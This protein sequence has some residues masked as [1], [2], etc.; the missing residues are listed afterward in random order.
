M[1]DRDV[2]DMLDS[3]ESQCQLMRSRIGS[4]GSRVR[5]PKRGKPATLADFDAALKRAYYPDKPTDCGACSDGDA[6]KC[7]AVPIDGDAATEPFSGAPELTPEELEAAKR[8]PYEF[9]YTRDKP[10]TIYA[11]NN[12]TG[13]TKYTV[14]GTQ[15]GD[16]SY[17]ALVEA[18]VRD[19]GGSATMAGITAACRLSLYATREAVRS[20]VSDG[21]L[22]KVG[23]KRGASYRLPDGA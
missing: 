19:L 5:K 22:I 20:L 6:P 13:T 1:N 17:P 21:R 4:E 9:R 10:L 12:I 15:P 14:G 2:L 18:T 16:M 7:D 23:D 3:I 11:G 8:R